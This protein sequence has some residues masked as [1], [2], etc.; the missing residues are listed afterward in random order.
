M[1]INRSP[2]VDPYASAP[3][4]T[5]FTQFFTVHAGGCMFGLPVDS[6]QT[7]FRL[8]AITPVPLGPPTVAGLVNLRGKIVT[9]VSLEK[10]LGLEPAPPS[11]STPLAV[12]LERRGETFALVVDAVGDAMECSEDMRIPSPR[13]VKEG[14]ARMTHSYYRSDGGIL[15]VLDVD[16]LFDLRMSPQTRQSDPQQPNIADPGGQA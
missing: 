13:H 16:A 1:T 3:V 9:A 5:R 14:R 7:I 4:R 2:Q 11:S 15:P 10:R 8:Q 6:V 12:A